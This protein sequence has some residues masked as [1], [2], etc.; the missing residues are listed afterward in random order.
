MKLFKNFEFSLTFT[1]VKCQKIETIHNFLF[2]Y[3]RAALKKMSSTGEL[4]K[5]SEFSKLSSLVHKLEKKTCHSEYHGL[6]YQTYRLGQISHFV[7]A[8]EFIYTTMNLCMQIN[9]QIP[10]KLHVL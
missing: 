2:I 7:S 10:T 9:A 8:T 6:F 3:F 5:V 4:A 1:L